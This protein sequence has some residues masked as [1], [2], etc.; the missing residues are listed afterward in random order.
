MATVA[1]RI[2]APA[3]GVIQVQWPNLANGD[4]GGGADI[5]RFPEKTLQMEGT[6]GVGGT[7]QFEGSN[8]GTNWRQMKDFEGT[9]I[10]LTAAGIVLISENPF[11][12]RPNITAGDGST[13]LTVTVSAN[14]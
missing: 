5:R 7:M 2:T 11:L 4:V 3:K 13:D 12:I 6:P 10:S 9:L 8:D 14:G 1:P